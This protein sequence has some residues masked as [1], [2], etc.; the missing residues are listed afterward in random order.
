MP[1]PGR[2]SGGNS[3]SDAAYQQLCKSI[4]PETGSTV[5]AY[6]NAGNLSWSASGL[7]RTC[8]F[9]PATRGSRISAGTTVRGWADQ[10]ALF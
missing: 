2:G 10:T 9:A 3:E 7:R 5:L 6:D 1:S 8:L 4:E